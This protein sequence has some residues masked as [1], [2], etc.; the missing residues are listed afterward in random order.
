[1]RSCADLEILRIEP[2]K[3]VVLYLKIGTKIK[4]GILF[5]VIS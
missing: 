4:I 2:E 5:S 1:L 3:L